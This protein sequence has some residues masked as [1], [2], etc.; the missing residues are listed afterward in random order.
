MLVFA[1]CACSS[2]WFF[3][4]AREM[5]ET[6][7]FIAKTM[8]LTEALSPFVCLGYMFQLRDLKLSNLEKMKRSGQF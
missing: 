3:L 5:F 6:S 2:E 1:L 7:Y 4:V 8:N